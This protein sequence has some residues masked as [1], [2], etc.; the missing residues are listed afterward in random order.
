VSSIPSDKLSGTKRGLVR[1]MDIW[2]SSRHVPGLKSASITYSGGDMFVD[3]QKLGLPG[4][5]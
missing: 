5:R 2:I 4:N 1:I 3:N